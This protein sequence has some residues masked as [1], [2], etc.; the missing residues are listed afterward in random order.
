MTNSIVWDLEKN[1]GNEKGT[2]FC[3]EN[4]NPWKKLVKTKGYVGTNGY[5][6]LLSMLPIP[7]GTPVAFRFDEFFHGILKPPRK[8]NEIWK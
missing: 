8:T 5:W 3:C 6:Y 4:W 2:H 1:P 7:I